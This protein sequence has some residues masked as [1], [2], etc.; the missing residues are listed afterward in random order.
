MLEQK[1]SHPD[2]W[3]S[4]DKAQS[5]TKKI[6]ALQNSIK[7]WESLQNDVKTDLELAQEFSGADDEDL[8]EEFTKK[9]VIFK[10]NFATLE[11]ETF[12]TGRFDS[13][14]AIVSISAG[15]GG[16]DAQDWAQMLEA[17]LLRFA[18][19]KGFKT[20][21]IDRQQGQEAGIKSSTFEVLGEYAY[22]WLQSESGVHRL[23][24]LS[25]YDADKARHTSFALVDVIPDLGNTD[26]IDI[27][28]E[29][30]RVDV[31]RASG[32]GGQSVNTTDSAVRIVHLPTNITVSVQNERSQQQ[33]KATALK[34]LKS[35]LIKK[36]E[37]ER[38]EQERRI[39]GEVKSAEWGSQIRSYV[40]HPYKLVKD[41]RTDLEAQDVDSV[42][43]GELDKFSEEYVRWLVRK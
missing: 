2:F 42:L 30:L 37:D 32:H 29:D 10:K 8:E 34:I 12:F 21:L 18:Q 39:R 16:T 22:G 27:K 24:R 20:N 38:L 26:D 31:F 23:V 41:H 13:L 3:N 43:A 17:M 40:L 15:A 19:K 14:G 5:I 36:Q 1:T 35:R 11:L 4:Q 25:P 28:E 9:L 7:I 33:N 6:A